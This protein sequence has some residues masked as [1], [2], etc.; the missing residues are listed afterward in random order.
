VKKTT[1]EKGPRLGNRVEKARKRREK[2][3]R[4]EKKGPG[5]GKL[6]PKRDGSDVMGV[7]QGGGTKNSI[8]IS[9]TKHQQKET[10]TTTSHPQKQKQT[11][12]RRPPNQKNSRKTNPPQ[13][14]QT[15]AE[16]D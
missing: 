9:T 12:T 3:K 4:G 16:K 10:P 11:P 1:R 8:K 2:V 14:H 13:K 6:Y 15:S 7:C 5:M